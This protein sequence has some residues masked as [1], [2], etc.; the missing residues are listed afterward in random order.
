MERYLL[1]SMEILLIETGGAGMA[2]ISKISRGNKK[3]HTQ[4]K[5]P[6]EGGRTD[7]IGG[8]AAARTVFYERAADQTSNPVGKEMFLS[9]IEDEKRNADAF[10][11]MPEL[12]DMKGRNAA[13]S[14]RKMKAFFEKTGDDLLKKITSTTDEVEALGIAMELEKRSIGLCERLS[15]QVMQSAKEKVV[16]EQLIKQERQRYAL[17]SNTYFFLADAGSCFMWDEHSIADGGTPWA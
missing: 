4:G 15:H 5:S 1:I 9:M 13:L 7:M 12:R 8:V 17:F 10:R 6:R 14:V 16:L 11:G 3:H 2:T